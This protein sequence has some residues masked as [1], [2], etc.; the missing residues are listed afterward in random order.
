MR[1]VNLIPSE[2]R[3]GGSVGAGR[4]EGAAYGVLALFVA[5]AVLAVMYGKAH[6]DVE[7]RKAQ[8]ATLGA[9][10]QRAQAQASQLAPYTSFIALR[11]QRE[12]AVATLVD[13]RFDWAHAFHEFGRVLGPATQITSLDGAIAAG[14]PAAVSSGAAATPALTAASATGSVASVTPAGSV[15][16]FNLT[17]CAIS[18]DAVA[19]M[20]QRL[21]LIDG[22]NTVT[23]L[24]STKSA[25]AAS[26][27][28]SPGGCPVNGPAFSVVVTFDPLP[29]T[30]AS[31]AAAKSAPTTTTVSA[32]GGKG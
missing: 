27:G 16:T 23:L 7:S 5:I 25:G 6:R 14:A 4:S 11:A 3:S 21:R 19:Q 15:P 31:A 29:S 13:S 9:Q 10:A 32:G 8:A 12:Q 18:Q 28:G 24:S 30:A 17:G 26:S 1:A 20:L 22:V 2:Q